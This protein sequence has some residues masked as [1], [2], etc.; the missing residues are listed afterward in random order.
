V[1]RYREYDNRAL[2]GVYIFNFPAD[3][4]EEREAL[5][6]EL[7]RRGLA[8]WARQT[9][10]ELYDIFSNKWVEKEREIESEKENANK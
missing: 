2:V 7:E 6:R 9:F 8:D 3:N 5:L 1:N 10:L 4:P